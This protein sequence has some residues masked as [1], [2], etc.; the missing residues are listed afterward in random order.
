MKRPKPKENNIYAQVALNQGLRDR[1][2]SS[3]GLQFGSVGNI[4]QQY[5]IKVEYLDRCLKFTA[6]EARLRHLI[7]KFHFSKTNYSNQEF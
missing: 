1:R 3:F 6:P 4:C 5:G 2:L 7:E